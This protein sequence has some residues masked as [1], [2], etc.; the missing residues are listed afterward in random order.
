MGK[1]DEKF[2]ALIKV[3]EEL[4]TNV[5]NAKLAHL[6]KELEVRMSLGN[7]GFTTLDPKYSYENTPEYIEHQKNALVLAIQEEKAK[8]RA[9]LNNVERNRLQRQEI[10]EMKAER[11][12]SLK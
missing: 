10:A 4:L 6:D 8:I 1:Y 7:K 12:G 11:E 5:Y 9:A 2:E 3:E